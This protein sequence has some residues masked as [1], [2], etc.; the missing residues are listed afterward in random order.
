M[1]Q[2]DY[3]LRLKEAI[4]INLSRQLKDN[5]T[6]LAQGKGGKI[7]EKHLDRDLVQKIEENAKNG[8]FELKKDTYTKELKKA[9][10]EFLKDLD[11]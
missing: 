2:R 6:L 5:T 7:I 9:I 8:I 1:L 10:E 3:G 4:H 11:V